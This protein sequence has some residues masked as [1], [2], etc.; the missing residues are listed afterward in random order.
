MNVKRVVLPY[1]RETFKSKLWRA[2]GHAA[3]MNQERDLSIQW[4]EPRE[5]WYR[6][7]VEGSRHQRAAE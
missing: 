4:N 6:M 2:I 5:F 7:P 3:I 1:E